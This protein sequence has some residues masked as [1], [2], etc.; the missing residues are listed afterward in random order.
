[1]RRGNKIGF[2][3]YF[4]EFIIVILGITIAFWLS[5]LGEDRKER[6]LEIQYLNDLRADLEKDL[7]LLNSSIASNDR[8]MQKLGEA[9]SFFQGQ[10]PALTYDS[11]PVYAD[12]VG[13]YNFF[14]PSDY[15]Y[16]S[17]QQSGD[18]KVLQDKDLKK[19]LIELYQSYELIEREHNNLSVALDDNFYPEYMANY[20]LI[21]DEIVNITYFK[22]P[23]FKNFV[24]FTMNETFVLNRFYNRARKIIESILEMNL[25]QEN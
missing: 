18:F 10:N 1:M 16:I 25:M 22:T 6:R 11:M 15:T 19:S 5:N 3:E 13:N 9:I 20:D 17:L 14:E 21:N 8:K 24:G 4:I 23:L 7:E 2:K 12:I